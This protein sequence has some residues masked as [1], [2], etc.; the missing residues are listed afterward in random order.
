MSS[1][2]S[3]EMNLVEQTKNQIRVLVGEITQLSK[4][5]IDPNEF[6][7]EFLPRV[8]SALAAVGGAIW[9][10][11]PGGLSL[12]YQ[13]NMKESRIQESEDSNK[14]HSRLLY[15]QL[16]GSMDGTLVQPHSGD[17]GADGAGNPTEF[18]LVFCPIKTELEE[19]GLIEIL[20]RP[21]TGPIAQKGYT[22][23]LSQMGVFAVDYYKNRQLRNFNDRQ[24]LWTQLEEFT[25]N[26]HKSLDLRETSY[27]VVNEGRRLVE[28]DRVSIAI[29][30][31]G[32]CRV[33]AISGQDM[34]D[35]RSTAVRL[36]EKLANSVVAANESVWYTGDTSDFAPQV[37]KAVEE[38]VD[39]SH[40][41]MIGV[42]PLSKVILEEK[43]EEEASKHEKPE[44]PF[45]AL[46]IEQIEDN[47][48]PERM[49]KRVEIVSEHA[50]SALGNA[51]DHNSVF[52][53]PLWKT[54]GKSKV[55]VTARML[56]KTVSVSLAV[57]AV[58]LLMIF[59]PRSLYMH[60]TG[61]L[62]PIER[63][64]V[65]SAITGKV[66]KVYVQHGT[67][68]EGPTPD[69]NDPNQYFPG[70]LVIELSST[71][72]D[73]KLVEIRGQILE[74]ETEKSNIHR[75]LNSIREQRDMP[76]EKAAERETQLGGN[77]EIAN[78]RLLNLQK[79]LQLL[80]LQAQDLLITSP[81]K[82][83]VLT[84]QPEETLQGVTVSPGQ[85]LLEIAD[86]SG[87]F[88]LELSMPEK[89]IGHIF[90]YQKKTQG[91]PL[92]VEFV[93]ASDANKR[94]YGT[95]REIHDRA[96]VRGEAGA[97]GGGNTVLIRVDIDDPHLLPEKLQ[98]GTSCSAKVLCGKAPLGYTLF[99][100]AIAYLQ[101]NVLF[102][103]Y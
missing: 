34:F 18:L 88:Y 4:S 64:K 41:K 5:D 77:I 16:K 71:E 91:Q 31:G 81:M 54:I 67:P 42:F 82:G 66:E 72:M 50:C 83:I 57:I 26:I 76:P 24:S 84:W 39:E 69:E 27:T 45:G 17:E 11:Q 56:P 62:W 22:R 25:R 80:E 6:H 29:L 68:V 58:I 51:L 32:K 21:D 85:E 10:L 98:P 7:A 33:E 95:V 35:K 87:P 8:V 36:L 59:F 48:I 2:Q 12:A 53:M 55:L 46:I 102:W 101:K 78:I 30:R 73:R 61:T 49:R 99:H 94:F 103:V 100:E 90:D 28:C 13:V 60:S 38:Y 14:R 65:F 44:P 79:S 20:Q 40:T 74:T 92:R 1:E 37:E 19:V 3:Y 89:R 75:E 63:Q 9:T 43:I 86:P 15:Q 96:E 23:F 97:A 93:L 47:R 52:L 70:S